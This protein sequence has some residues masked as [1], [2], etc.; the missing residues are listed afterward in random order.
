MPRG[1]FVA[2]LL[3]TPGDGIDDFVEAVHAVQ[4]AIGEI[5]QQVVVAHRAAVHGAF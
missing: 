2:E 5:L 4:L 1:Y 3:Q